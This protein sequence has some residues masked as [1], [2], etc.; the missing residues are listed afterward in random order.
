VCRPRDRID[1]AR[2]AQDGPPPTFEHEGEERYQRAYR[3]TR[4]NV[5]AWRDASQIYGYDETSVQRVRRD[6]TDR[7][8][9]LMERRD[10]HAGEG[11][12]QGYLPLLS[13][14]APQLPQWRGQ[15]SVAFPDNFNIGLSFYYNVFV[16]EHNAFVDAFRARVATSPGEDSGL[17]DPRNPESVIAYRDVTADELY[18][19]ARLV[20][21]AEIAKVHTIEWTTQLLYD[22]P[23]YRGMNAN[24]SGLF[25]DDSK[26]STI[27]ERIRQGLSELPPPVPLAG[28]DIRVRWPTVTLECPV[29]LHALGHRDT[30]V[31]LADQEDRRGGHLGE[32]PEW[33]VLPPGCQQTDPR[34][35]PRVSQSVVSHQSAP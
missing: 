11:E 18:E 28:R 22:E 33:R 29:Y 5:T 1:Q 20:V 8:K 7:A 31:V 17:R 3:T 14:D 27:A 32:T 15:E 34:V 9:L 10:G 21:S 16:R 30:S 13:P 25:D 2:I 19:A 35:G 4:N 24:W 6:P 23:L 26:L 12:L